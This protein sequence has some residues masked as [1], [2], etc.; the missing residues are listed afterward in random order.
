MTSTITKFIEDNQEMEMEVDAEEQDKEFPDEPDSYS[1]KSL[2]LEEAYDEDVHS[3]NNN[4]SRIDDSSGNEELQNGGDE[5][6]EDSDRED[7]PKQEKKVNYKECQKR[8]ISGNIDDVQMEEVIGEAVNRMQKCVEEM[9]TNSGILQIVQNAMKLQEQLDQQTTKGRTVNVNMIATNAKEGD[10]GRIYGLKGKHCEFDMS[11]QFIHSA[12]VDENYL[13][14]AAHV[15]QVTQ[16]K[17]EKDQYIDLARLVPRDRIEEE[18]DNAMQMIVRQGKTFWKPA[19]QD[20]VVINSLAK[21]EQAFRVFTD[22][23]TRAHPHHANELIQYQ[24]IIHTTAATYVW[25]N[26]YLYDKDFRIHM[27]KFPTQNWGII[28][29]QAWNLR[30]CDKHRSDWFNN[31]LPGQQNKGKGFNPQDCCKQFNREHCTYGIGCKFEHRCLYC[32]K[33][34]H[35]ILNCRKLKADKNSYGN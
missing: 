25:E 21:W 28:L 12:M 23:Y 5:S 35:G 13:I 11:N 6:Q 29:Q 22:I 31:S 20:G 18:E 3:E 32:G 19:T 17:I 9:L 2:S 27:S 7:N 24:H 16:D 14:V 8:K 30:L 10:G 1:D 26:I 34:G 15:D 33:F 4:A